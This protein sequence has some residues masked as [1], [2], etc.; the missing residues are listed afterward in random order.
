MWVHVLAVGAV[1]VD[2]GVQ[3]E[4]RL[5]FELV[6][7]SCGILLLSRPEGIQDTLPCLRACHR[8]GMICKHACFALLYNTSSGVGSVPI[9]D[10]AN[11]IYGQNEDVCAINT[12]IITV[13]RKGSR[14]MTRQTCTCTPWSCTNQT[15]HWSCD[16]DVMAGV[17]IAASLASDLTGRRWLV[18]CGLGCSTGGL[19]TAALGAGFQVPT[20]GLLLWPRTAAGA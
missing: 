7:Y 2:C 20:G 9:R 13:E 11:D 12:N 5:G 19:L 15:I 6:N 10:V 1:R 18:V 14:P 16:A 3:V 17:L 8:L 4:G